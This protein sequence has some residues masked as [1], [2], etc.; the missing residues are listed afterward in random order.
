MVGVSRGQLNRA[1]SELQRTG[2]RSA[3]PRRAGDVERCMTS[4]DRLHL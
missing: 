2:C 1:A 3:R 4:K